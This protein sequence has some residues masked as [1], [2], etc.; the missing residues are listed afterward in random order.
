MDEPRSAR[1]N[2][3]RTLLIA[4]SLAALIA[5]GF[6]VSASAGQSPPDQAAQGGSAVSQLAEPG[7]TLTPAKVSADASKAAV[8][9][10][11]Q[12]CA[13]GAGWMR[14]R[15][16]GLTL[17]GDDTVTLTGSS[18]GTYTLTSHNGAS[19]EFF[20]RAFSGSCVT[21]T[22]KLT[23]AGSRYSI[24]AYQSGRQALAAASVRIAAVGDICGDAC[25]QTAPLVSAMAPAAVFTAGDNA[26]DSGTLSE[27]NGAYDRNWGKF[28]SIVHP[29]PGNHEYKTSGAKGYF[30]YYQGKGVTTGDRDKGYYSVD[31]GD[32]H[33]VSLNSNIS[34]SA[35]STQERWL[36]SDLAASTKP[37]TM[38]YWHHARFSSGDH[39]DS[40]GTAPLMKALTDFKADVAVWGHDHHYERFAPAM[41]NGTRDTANGMRSFVIGT[42]GRALYSARNTSAGPSE[43][44]NNNTYGVGQFDLTATGYSFAFKPV[45]GRTFTDSVSGTC[46][47]KGNGPG[48]GPTPT[49]TPTPTSTGPTPT[50]GGPV[51]G[52]TYQLLNANSG[53]VL[54]SPTKNGEGGNLVQ[55]TGGNFSNQKFTATKNSDGTYQLKVK[56]S[57]LC[58]AG[59]PGSTTEGTAVQ[60]RTCGTA[61]DQK[62]TIVAGGGGF[63]LT[64][65]HSGKCLDV[66]GGSKDDGAR[67]VQSS[68]DGRVSQQWKFNPA[69]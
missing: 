50:P 42:G 3:G 45:A 2:Y 4:T 16:N 56:S 62:W 43:A 22:P 15:F 7:A 46:H 63:T 18:G 23:Q 5:G 30:D 9:A 38:A 66:S 17:R 52:T 1:R 40:G 41:S 33:V 47:A 34:T 54:D 61:S 26:Y 68:C 69:P 10:E 67:I 12:V 32:W 35:G 11:R 20:T 53:K 24:D 19:S 48:P 39:G 6:M 37:C 28:N 65:Q 36:R 29:A 27:F 8:H 57:G 60:Q 59:A 21:V 58:A 55:W 13:E 44:F 51:S 49:P 25:N 31:V 64:A 14:L